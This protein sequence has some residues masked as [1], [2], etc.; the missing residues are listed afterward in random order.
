MPNASPA[1]GSLPADCR[2][3]SATQPPAPFRA[4]AAAYIPSSNLQPPARLTTGTPSRRSRR[5]AS[6]RHCR[7]RASAL[8]SGGAAT[9][10]P[11]VID[12]LWIEVGSLQ[13]TAEQHF[14]PHVVLLLS[15]EFFHMIDGRLCT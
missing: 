5:T 9:H 6:Y 12:L 4:S 7:A 3:D 13:I 14:V 10:F 11:L 8:R 15:F 2:S 1:S